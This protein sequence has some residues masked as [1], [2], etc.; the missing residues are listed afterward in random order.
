LFKTISHSGS[1]TQPYSASSI[2]TSLFMNGVVRGVV[3]SKARGAKLQAE[4]YGI[5]F[6][7]LITHAPNFV[8]DAR[9][10]LS[11]AQRFRFFARKEHAHCAFGHSSRRRDDT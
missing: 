7:L 3:A 5:E 1:P 11:T 6:A 4:H 2:A 8:D 10:A 9:L